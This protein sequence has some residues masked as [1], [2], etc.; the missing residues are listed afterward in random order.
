MQGIFNQIS[1]ISV[2]FVAINEVKGSF[3]KRNKN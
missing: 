3:K 2:I 1:K